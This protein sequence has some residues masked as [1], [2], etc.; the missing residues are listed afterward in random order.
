MSSAAN[1]LTTTGNIWVAVDGQSAA[2]CVLATFADMHRGL[3]QSKSDERV[4]YYVDHGGLAMDSASHCGS[5]LAADA[6]EAIAGLAVAG[7]VKS[8]ESG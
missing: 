3:A 1:R 5:T 6:R 7:A 4:A 2:A 8:L